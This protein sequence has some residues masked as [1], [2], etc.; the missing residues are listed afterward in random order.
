MTSLGPG[1]EFDADRAKDLALGLADVGVA[2]TV[3]F[4]D[5]RD[6]RGA[7]GHR[8]DGLHAADAVNF[9]DADEME[10]SE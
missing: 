6:S 7:K 3:D 4:V 9:V 5:R 2:G 1:S 8:A 10:R